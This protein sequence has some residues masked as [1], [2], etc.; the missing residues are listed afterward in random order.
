MP[1]TN[2]AAQRANAGN[3]PDVV[4]TTT[5]NDIPEHFRNQAVRLISRQFHL[6]PPV[7][8]VVVELARI[9]GAK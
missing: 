1:E 9:G 2:G 8:A 7:A 5:A 4:S 6:S 3:R